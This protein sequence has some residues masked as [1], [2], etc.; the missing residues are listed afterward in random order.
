MS[1]RSS[2]TTLWLFLLGSHNGK[3]EERFAFDI[4]Y[5]VY[6]LE[7]ASVDTKNIKV[8]VDKSGEQVIHSV[9]SRTG[10]SSRPIIETTELPAVLKEHQNHTDLV[11]FVTGHGSTDCIIAKTPIRPYNMLQMIKSATNFQRAILY[12]GQC[13]AGIFNFLPVDRTK[14]QIAANTGCEIIVIGAANLSPSVSFLTTE[15]FGVEKFPWRANVFLL[16][17]FSW[18]QNPKDIDGDNKC[19]I[20]DSYKAAGSFANNFFSQ[21]CASLLGEKLSSLIEIKKDK[22]A[23][24]LDKK[25]ALEELRRAKIAPTPEFLKELMEASAIVESMA[26]I[27][28]EISILVNRQEAWILNAR[29]AQHIEF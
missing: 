14:A 17:L 29:P 7:K 12:L 13:F 6:S 23:F 26:T 21:A 27:N 11:I 28:N 16:G 18:I 5:G 1:L 8:L 4:A 10:L 19:T 22:G 9:F 2:K 24:V 20:M 15:D 3:V 25:A